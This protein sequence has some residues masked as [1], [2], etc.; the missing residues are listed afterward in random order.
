MT[1]KIKGLVFT[2]DSGGVG[3]AV[4]VSVMTGSIHLFQ[5]REIAENKGGRNKHSRNAERNPLDTYHRKYE[6]EQLSGRIQV[7]S[8]LPEPPHGQNPYK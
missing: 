2:F 1:D 4:S 8:N 3:V 6:N 5:L 7:E